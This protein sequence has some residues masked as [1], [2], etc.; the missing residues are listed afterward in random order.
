MLTIWLKFYNISFFV[1]V[2]I[3]KLFSAMSIR[4]EVNV[5]VIEKSVEDYRPDVI[6]PKGCF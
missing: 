2:L 4:F 6:H 3:S 5:K 1:D